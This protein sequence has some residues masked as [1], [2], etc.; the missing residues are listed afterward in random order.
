MYWSTR[1]YR[2]LVSVTTVTVGKCCGVFLLFQGLIAV[3]G[4]GRMWQ[5]S[6]AGG[7]IVFFRYV[8]QL[9]CGIFSLL[10]NIVVAYYTSKS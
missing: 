2:L 5:I 1:H 3:G 10:S 6:N 8:Y 9:W 7:R 4:F